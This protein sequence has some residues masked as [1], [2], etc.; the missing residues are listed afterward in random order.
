MELVILAIVAGLSFASY[1]IWKQA[2]G[3]PDEPAA[4]GALDGPP[5][6][7]ALLTDGER[8]IHT[9]RPGDVVSHLGQ[10]F[11]VE[12]VLTFSDDGRVTRLYRLVDG[13]QERWLGARP[14]DDS[15]LLLDEAA[16]FAVEA[17][18]PEAITRGGLPFRLAHRE[19]ALCAAAGAVGGEREGG[20]AQLYEYVGAGTARI[21]ALVWPGRVD[22]FAGERVARHFVDILPGAATRSSA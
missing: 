18:G 9:M 16:D 14:G 12:G 17:N 15:P 1:A 19:S 10:D 13:G 4:P 22:T 3:A 5:G 20:R 11:L 2:R 8:T 21:L 6:A 7:A